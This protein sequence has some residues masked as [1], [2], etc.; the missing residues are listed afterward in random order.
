MTI[1]LGRANWQLNLSGR[2]SKHCWNW[3]IDARRGTWNSLEIIWIK[4]VHHR[5]LHGHTRLDS[6]TCWITL[7]SVYDRCAIQKKRPFKW[8]KTFSRL[9]KYSRFLD[10]LFV[11]FWIFHFAISVAQKIAV[12]VYRNQRGSSETQFRGNPFHLQNASWDN[13]DFLFGHFW[14]AERRDSEKKIHD[15]N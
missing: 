11:V 14:G 12:K 10:D 7:L 5:P 9:I 2:E 6:L 1:K 15:V 4:Q 8:N 13:R 3:L